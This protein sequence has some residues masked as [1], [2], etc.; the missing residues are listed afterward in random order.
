[1]TLRIHI[2]HELASEPPRKKEEEIF[3]GRDIGRDRFIS[4]HTAEV[5]DS[6]I[7]QLLLDALAYV[8]KL[9]TENR[10]KLDRLAERLI[11]KEMLES[12]EVETLIHGTGAVAA[13]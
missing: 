1:M 7:K 9:L 2:H 5:I 8:R 3:L 12:E 13:G 4:N 11:E 10:S 6:E